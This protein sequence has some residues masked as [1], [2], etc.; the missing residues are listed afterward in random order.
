MEAGL[1]P[2]KRT[3]TVLLDSMNSVM[4]FLKFTQEIGEDFQD[5]KLPSLDIQIWVDGFVILFEFFS[6][7]M[8]SNLV[9]HAQ[10]A[11]SEDTKLSTLAEE[12]CRRLRKT[13]RRLDYSERMEIL[14]EFSTKMVT[15][16]HTMKFMRRALNEKRWDERE[17][18]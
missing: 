9:V 11:L 12:T 17:T 16:G 8:S 4:S 7:T 1:S 14:E 3:A 5:G 15:S 10:G 2:T 6:K 13:S 18:G